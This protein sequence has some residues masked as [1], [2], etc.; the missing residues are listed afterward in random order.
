MFNLAPM[1]EKE[2][3]AA[4]GGNYADR[5]RNLRFVLR[6]AKKEYMLDQPLGEA[7]SKDAA[8]EEVAAYATRSDD[9]ELV[10]CFMLT[11][12]DPE[13]QKRF[14]R[15]ITQFIIGSLEILYKKKARTK[16]FEL[17]KALIKCKMKEGYSMSEHIVKLA[18]YVDRLASL[19]FG[20][21]PTLGIDIVLASLPHLTMVSS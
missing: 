1:L 10:Q 7:P 20:I 6:S 17:T 4:N 18:G 21:P 2:K 9:Y 15:S 12:M 14:E 11:C 19:E 13:L 5:I 8:P 16:R 3:L